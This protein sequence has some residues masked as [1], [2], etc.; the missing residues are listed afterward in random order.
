[1]EP[2][3]D[4]VGVRQFAFVWKNFPRWIEKRLKARFGVASGEAWVEG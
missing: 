4:G 1:L 3:A 2:V